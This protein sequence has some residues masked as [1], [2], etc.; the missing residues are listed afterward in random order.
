MK[1]L[2]NCRKFSG[3]TRLYYYQAYLHQ[4]DYSF[5]VV[6]LSVNMITQTAETTNFDDISREAECMTSNKRLDFD[7]DPDHDSDPGIFSL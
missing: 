4:G 5:G 1:G 3:N 6:G 7:G 2:F